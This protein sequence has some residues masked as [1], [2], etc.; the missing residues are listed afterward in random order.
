MT[1]GKIPRYAYD[2]SFAVRFRE[3]S[4]WKVGSQS[5]GK[6]GLIWYTNGSKTN[7]STE[8]GVYGYGSGRKLRSDLGKYARVFQAE[9]YIIKA[10][11]VENVDSEYGNRKMYILTDSQVAMKALDN[12]QINSKFIWD[13]HQFLVK[14]AKYN[15]VQ[16]IWLAGHEVFDGNETVD[17]LAKLGFECPLIEPEAAC[18]ISAGIAKKD[19][20]DWR[21]SDHKN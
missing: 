15:R 19:V 13:C 12:Y 10:R 18:R 17:Q 5:D 4:E 3:R 20:K 9:V 7:K 2:K 14:L 1:E 8:A 6:G 21:S 16:L 11:A